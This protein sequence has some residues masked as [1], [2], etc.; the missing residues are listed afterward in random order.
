MD[1][2]QRPTFKEIVNILSGYTETLAGYL[3]MSSFNPFTHEDHNNSPEDGFGND[4]LTHPDQL[5]K[6][7]EHHNSK[8][9]AKASRSPRGSPRGSK[10][11][12]P[13]PSPVSTDQRSLSVK[14]APMIR[15]DPGSPTPEYDNSRI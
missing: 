6:I 5:A 3:D 8:K 12:T 2:N 13:L 4:I 9:K 15:I 10:R 1:S 11:T 14:N 7:Y